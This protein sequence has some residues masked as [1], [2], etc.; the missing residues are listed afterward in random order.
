M[1][2]K[3]SV[4]PYV[5]QILLTPCYVV[6]LSIVQ[7]FHVAMCTCTL[8][9]KDRRFLVVQQ[10]QARRVMFLSIADRVKEPIPAPLCCNVEADVPSLSYYS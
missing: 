10:G 2:I 8:C 4:V 6:M 7:Q 5:Q 3:E 1:A 9:C